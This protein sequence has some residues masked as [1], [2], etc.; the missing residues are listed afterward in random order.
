MQITYGLFALGWRG[1]QRSWQHY[2]KC[3]DMLH[4]FDWSKWTSGTS[5]ERRR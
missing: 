1:G 4:D 2:E 5:A 3:C